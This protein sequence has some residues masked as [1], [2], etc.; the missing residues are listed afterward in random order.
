MEEEGRVRSSR[1]KR[2]KR[3]GRERKSGP[4]PPF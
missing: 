1:G 4:S 3:R 2:K